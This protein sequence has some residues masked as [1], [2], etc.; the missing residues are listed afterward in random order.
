ML[1]MYITVTLLLSLSCL[2]S[3]HL[4]RQDSKSLAECMFSKAQSHYI[5]APVHAAS[6]PGTSPGVEL[7]SEMSGMRFGISLYTKSADFVL[8]GF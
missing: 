1:T 2:N 7:P 4:C 6:V 8:S 3:T 5:S